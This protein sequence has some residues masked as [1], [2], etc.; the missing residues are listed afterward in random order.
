SPTT[1][2]ISNNANLVKAI[3]E[4]KNALPPGYQTETFSAAGLGTA[5]GFSIDM[6]ES[7]HAENQ[8]GHKIYLDA[9]GGTTYVEFDLTAHV[10]SN[11]VAEADYLR[12]QHNYPG[13]IAGKPAIAAEPIL[14][15]VGA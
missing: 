9:P 5:A 12:S 6:P 14:G 4:P 8:M 13:Y 1:L 7:W 3:D 11:M 2:R 15:T 10:K